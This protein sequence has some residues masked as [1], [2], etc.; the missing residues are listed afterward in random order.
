MAPAVSGLGHWP[1]QPEDM[2][3]EWGALLL[4]LSSLEAFVTVKQH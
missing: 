3:I 2:E 1:L 4:K